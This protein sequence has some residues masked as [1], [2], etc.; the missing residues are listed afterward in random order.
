M[1]PRGRWRLAADSLPDNI[2]VTPGLV[3]YV[4]RR[5]R[6]WN[7]RCSRS[8]A[9]SGLD[10]LGWVLWFSCRDRSTIVDVGVSID[11]RP[12]ADRL[13]LRDPRAI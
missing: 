2:M 3:A 7:S 8:R 6:S 10:M 5:S 13:D 11:R 4:F 9:F 12:L 1:Q